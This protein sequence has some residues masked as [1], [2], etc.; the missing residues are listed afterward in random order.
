[1]NLILILAKQ[2]Y[3]LIDIIINKQYSIMFS[4]YSQFKK[5]I[6]SFYTMCAYEYIFIRTINSIIKKHPGLSL[7]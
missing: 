4:W 7:S 6:L 3:K 1:M 2:Y 5:K